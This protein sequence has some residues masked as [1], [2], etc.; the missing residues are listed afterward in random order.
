MNDKPRRQQPRAG[1]WAMAVSAA[2]ACL[3]R[4]LDDPNDNFGGPGLHYTVLFGSA[5][6]GI[7]AL[8][9]LVVQ[10]R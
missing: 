2:F 6:V 9:M 8:V 5:A 4:L 1:L 7:A 3:S 10:R